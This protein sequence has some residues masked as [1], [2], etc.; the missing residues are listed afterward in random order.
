MQNSFLNFLTLL[1]YK[2][3]SKHIAI[4]LISTLL[5]TVLSSFIFLSA[6]IKHDS[7]EAL[8]QQPDF[9]VQRLQG[10][11]SVDIPIKRIEDYS[12]ITGVSYVSAR[13]FGRYFTPDRKHYF[14]IIGVDLFD[15][16]LVKWI[17]EILG[18]T[19]IK[20][21]LSKNSMIIGSG[22]KEYL[23]KNYYD[24][25]FN[26]T[27]PSGKNIKVDI[28]SSF[29]KQSN[30]ISSDFVLMQIDLAREIL[31]IDPNF[32]TDIILNIPNPAERENVKFKLLSKNYDTRVITKDELFK[33]YENLFNYQG[34]IFLV[35]FIV[36][37]IT[38]MLILYQRYSMIN[39]SDKKEIAILRAVGW[40]IK[41]VIKLKLTESLTIAILAFF[42]GTIAAYIYVFYFGAP[43]LKNIF[44]GFGNLTA[45]INFTPV[46]NIADVVSLF[47]IFIIPFTASILIPV[48]KIA[49]TDSTEALK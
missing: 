44:I 15:E 29:D 32:A 6:S 43:I 19:D 39:S 45:D 33:E 25:Y 23:H 20:K 35:G 22:V 11:R 14:T 24:D 31:G 18:K 36:C 2:H 16:Q 1:V 49:V 7:L 46:I 10:G 47:L 12:N 48:W 9:T 17:N 40:S 41:D 42:T 4:F 37:L 3:R 27:T 38:F 28:F 26:F 34:G 30:I 13:V 8:K 21:F 5:I